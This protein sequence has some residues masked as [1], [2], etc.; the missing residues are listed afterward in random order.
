MEFM[1]WEAGFIELHMYVYGLVSLTLW[2][3]NNIETQSHITACCCMPNNNVP[4]SVASAPD[5]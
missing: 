1:Y 4:E 5:L 2:L 3:M